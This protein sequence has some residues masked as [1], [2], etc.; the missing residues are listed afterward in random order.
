FYSLIAVTVAFGLAW[1]FKE[2]LS[3]VIR[4]PWRDAVTRLNAD[5]VAQAEA[6]LAAH[7]EL[8][9]SKYFISDDPKNQDL[10]DKIDDRL[11]MFGASEA[12]FFA[13]NTSLYFALFA[14]SPFV[15]WQAWA[16]VGAGLY[17]HEKRAILKYFP[18]SVFLFLAGVVFCYVY[19]I[20]IGLYFL[21]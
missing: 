17:R 9:R 3:D 11:A 8:P 4:R 1:W 14:A 6:E 16:F 5:L 20:P 13:L 12:F 7:P 21:S 18:F 10:R 15:L 2:Q 19:V